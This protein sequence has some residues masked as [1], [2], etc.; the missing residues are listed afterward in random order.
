MGNELEQHNQRPKELGVSL[1]LGM[2]TS[3]TENVMYLRRAAALGYRH[4]FTSLHI[5]EADEQQILADFQEL[6]QT[7]NQL[8]MQ[9][10]ADISPR[11][12]NLLGASVDNLAPLRNLGLSGL[13]LDFGFSAEEIARIVNTSGMMIEINASIVDVRDIKSILAAGADPSHMQACHNYYPRPDTGIGYELFAE[14]SR[15]LREMGLQVRAFIPSLVNPRGPIHAG[16]PTLESHRSIPSVTA[17]K[18]LWASGLVDTVLFGDPLASDAELGA[19]AAL[20][21]QVI[22]LRVRAE[23]GLSEAETK[24]LN[25]IHTNRMDPGE[26]VIRSQEARGAAASERVPARTALPR[27][28]GTVT[29]DNDLYLRYKGELQITLADLKADEKVNV[30]ATV[31]PE[32]QFLLSFITPGKQFAFLLED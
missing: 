22:T 27:T 29:I 15:V 10:T 2:G 12:F 32:E 19:V 24:L 20:D 18:H 30:T 3:L 14:R 16:L 5:P 21:P 6:I 13:R 28:M 1:F 11:T 17:A 8:S 31:V 25:M 4:V 23:A 26:Y 9:V 7:V